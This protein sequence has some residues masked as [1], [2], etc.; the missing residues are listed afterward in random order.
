MKIKLAIFLII[1]IFSGCVRIYP[2]GDGNLRGAL[3]DCFDKNNLELCKRSYDDLKNGTYMGNGLYGKKLMRIDMDIEERQKWLNKLAPK[4]KEY[5]Q[6]QYQKKLKDDLDFIKKNKQLC[7]EKKGLFWHKYCILVA[8]KSNQLNDFKQA[9][10]YYDKACV[11]FKTNLTN[12]HVDS[13]TNNLELTYKCILNLNNVIAGNT[14]QLAEKAE[15][16]N[17]TNKALYFYRISC[18]QNNAKAC[19]RFYNI[20]KKN[21]DF[22]AISEK[23]LTKSC[24]LDFAQACFEFGKRIIIKYGSLSDSFYKFDKSCQLGN[25]EGCAMLGVYYEKNKNYQKAFKL[26]Q[27]SCN[28]QSALACNGLG[29]IYDQGLGILR[30]HQKAK[31]AY[32]KACNLGYQIGCDNYSRLDKMR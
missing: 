5:K 13:T 16:F 10:E 15:K 28:K 32:S 21:S 11:N 6:Q 7:E 17:N 26:Y 29:D 22:E 30:N 18:D 31:D 2:Q 20:S 9:Q 4:I 25:N 24:D 14:F 12:N 1:L 8:E 3:D 27:Q 19:Y 23:Y